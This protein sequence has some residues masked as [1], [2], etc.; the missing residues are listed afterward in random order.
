MLIRVTKLLLF[1]LIGAVAWAVALRYFAYAAFDG[2]FPSLLMGCAFT[3][4]SALFISFML[5]VK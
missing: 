2:S 3:I 4:L 1:G 5:E